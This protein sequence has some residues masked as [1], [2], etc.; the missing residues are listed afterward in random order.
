MPDRVAVI[1]ELAREIAGS[2]FVDDYEIMD[3]YGGDYHEALTSEIE[4]NLWDENLRKDL[5]V[6]FK[7]MLEK[8]PDCLVTEHASIIRRMKEL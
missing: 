4:S 7:E 5:I 8:V 2:Y 3:C 6:H 1:E